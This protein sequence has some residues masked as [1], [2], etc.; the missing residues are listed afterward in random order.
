MRLPCDVRT[1][2]GLTAN[3]DVTT[4]VQ[5]DTPFGTTLRLAVDP[6]DIGS[7]PFRLEADVTFRTEVKDVSMNR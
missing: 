6:D 3:T 2:L 7:G 5:G 4:A 1:I